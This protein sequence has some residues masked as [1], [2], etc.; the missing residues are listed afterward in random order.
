MLDEIAQLEPVQRIRTPFNANLAA[1]AAAEAAIRD[2][3]YADAVRERTAQEL[4]SLTRE[5][6]ALGL[7]VL[8]SSANFYLVRF[9]CRDGLT[10]DA[11]AAFMEARGV[12]P[13]PVGAGGPE[14]CLRITIGRPHENEAVISALK[15]FVAGAEPAIV[16]T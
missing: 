6:N 14:G 5:L 12:I 1:L 13:R 8:P 10:E 3:E 16:G 15:A 4:A 9:P 11:A 2:V 7:E